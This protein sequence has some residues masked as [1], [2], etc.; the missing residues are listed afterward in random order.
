[1]LN[2]SQRPATASGSAYEQPVPSFDADLVSVG[3][4][5]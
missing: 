5:G 2:T 1:M 4:G 3:N